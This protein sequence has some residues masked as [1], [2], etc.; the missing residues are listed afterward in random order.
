MRNMNNRQ[1]TT[2]TIRAV[3]R[4]QATIQ[5]KGGIKGAQISRRGKP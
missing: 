3:K 5:R 4:N 2:R 1:A